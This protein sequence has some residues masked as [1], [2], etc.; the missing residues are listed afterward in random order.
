MTH[1]HES[2]VPS[3]VSSCKTGS[4]EVKQ[5]L[6]RSNTYK[7]SFIIINLDNLENNPRNSTSKKSTWKKDPSRWSLDMYN[8][9]HVMNPSLEVDITPRLV[10][11]LKMRKIFLKLSFYKKLEYSWTNKNNWEQINIFTSQVKM[12]LSIILNKNSSKIGK[13]SRSNFFTAEFFVWQSCKCFWIFKMIPSNLHRTNRSHSPDSI[14]VI[15]IC[16]L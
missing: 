6:M 3:I 7:G 15:F 4:N 2:W 11:D 5:S 14:Q 16:V 12:D 10:L 1:T 8:W 9:Y 13:I